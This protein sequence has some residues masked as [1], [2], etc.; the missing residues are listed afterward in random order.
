MQDEKAQITQQISKIIDMKLNASTS[1]KFEIY[2][3][4][5]DEYSKKLD[6]VNF[7]LNKLQIKG[8]QDDT[9]KRFDAIKRKLK[10]FQKGEI[11]ID[12]ELIH[13]LIKRY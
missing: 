9:V 10:E 12:G 7:E 8:I 5:Y 6:K 1:D 11:D 3:K 4:K 13:A 2:D